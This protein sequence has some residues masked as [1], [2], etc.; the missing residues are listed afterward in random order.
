MRWLIAF[1]A[2]VFPVG[3]QPLLPSPGV[4]IHTALNWPEMTTT[5]SPTY[6]WPPFTTARYQLPETYVN[7]LKQAG[8]K[9]IR[10]TVG[11]GIFIT[12]SPAQQKQLDAILRERV[13]LLVK[14]GFT[15]VL[16]FHPVKQDKRVM[17][18]AFTQDAN[19]T[20]AKAFRTLLKRTAKMLSTFPQEKVA[21]EILNEPEMKDWSNAQ[22]DLW[23]RMIETYYADVRRVAPKLKVIVSGCCS[24][25]LPGLLRL[26]PS[27]ADANTLFTFHY[28][29]PFAFTHQGA[30]ALTDPLLPVQY[31][32]G[33]PF[34]LD[35][36]AIARA[37][38]V[39]LKTL[40]RAKLTPLQRNEAK[41]RV[42]KS[43]QQ[44]R[45]VP[46]AAAIGRAFDKASAWVAQHNLKS[47]QIYLG[48]FGVMRPRTPEDSRT[49]WLQAMV[50]EANARGF[51]W[52]YWSA[53]QPEY[54]GLTL[55]KEKAEFDPVVLRG[56]GM[57]SESVPHSLD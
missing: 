23:Q 25:S 1:V 27:F 47:E 17:P 57:V 44:L 42:V 2:M 11:L 16:D 12:A 41:L 37:E 50:N 26:N 14:H 38:A 24:G 35:G 9:H 4:S 56:L 55:N 5:A 43:V 18:I 30:T 51:T 34:P 39:A 20:Q 10:L 33:V 13:A 54:M 36:A 22:A 19:A 29:E 31:F 6:A 21:L 3:A 45:D 40:K 8:F 48:E 32:S 28:Y 46:D 15:V 53:D 7:G 49:R 52:A